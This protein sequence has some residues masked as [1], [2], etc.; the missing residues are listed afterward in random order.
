MS[1]D[2]PKTRRAQQNEY[3]VELTKTPKIA[4]KARTRKLP[5]LAKRAKKRRSHKQ[6]VCLTIPETARFFKV[7]KAPRDR[8]IFSL[9]YY[10]GLRASELGLLKLSDYRQGS[11]LNLD[12]IRLVRLKGSISG[13]CAVVPAAAQ[14]VRAWLR[15]R[16]HQE[17]PLFPSRQRG[18]I[19]RFQIF[20]LMRRYCEA[21]DIPKEKQHPHCLRHSTAVHLLADRREGV[22]D[23]QRHLGHADI[24]S[25]MVYLQGLTDE[26]NEQRIRRLATWR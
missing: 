2:S 19:S 24:R 10:H 16:G 14:A 12:R 11:S 3:I 8:G 9:A 7:I 18:P 21:A 5:D 20:R 22:C 6:P 25:T 26:F 4:R 13:E 1:K 17:G 23:V 15:K